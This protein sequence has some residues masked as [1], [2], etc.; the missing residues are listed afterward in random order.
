M[1]SWHDHGYCPNELLAT[2]ISKRLVK[3][4]IYQLSVAEAE[5]GSRDPAFLQVAID[6]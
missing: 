2:V 4:L 6:S 3:D 5:M 1:S